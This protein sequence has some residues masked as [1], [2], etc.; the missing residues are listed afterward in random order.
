MI[1]TLI[2]W[3]F[4]VYGVFTIL[5]QWMMRY[6]PYA[7]G[8]EAWKVH[9][10]VH[11]SEICLEG[12]IRSLVHLSRLKGQP[13]QLVVCDYGSTDQT[14]RILRTFQ[15]ENPYL[16]DQIEVVT[17]GSY[18]LISMD[19]TEKRDFWMTIDL[20]SNDVPSGGGGGATLQTT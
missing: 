14:E 17:K 11:N 7:R 18:C 12:A 10:L 6:N 16:F 4:A 5:F 1:A 13:L 20:R 15:K 19:E 2:L 9:L 3:L 8:R